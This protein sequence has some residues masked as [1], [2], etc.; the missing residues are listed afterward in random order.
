MTGTEPCPAFKQQQKQ[1]GVVVADLVTKISDPSLVIA[2][3]S[4]MRSLLDKV[5]MFMAFNSS[6]KIQEDDP[7]VE[8]A[9]KVAS[10]LADLSKNQYGSLL[11]Q[12]FLK[13]SVSVKD[14]SLMGNY[15]CVTNSP[16]ARQDHMQ[17]H[18]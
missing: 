5:Q 4:F 6:L 15:L 11:V 12:E 13:L 14:E 10:N 16:C 7:S 9:Q 2:A 18:W 1:P 17:H 3:T 8:E